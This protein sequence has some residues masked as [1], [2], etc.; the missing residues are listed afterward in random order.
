MDNDKLKEEIDFLNH[1]WDLEEK[2]KATMPRF[3]DKQLISMFAP[4]SKN[5]LTSAIKET[6]QEYSSLAKSIRKNFE[7]VNLCLADDFSKWFCKTQ[8]DIR[9]G[10]RF[11]ELKRRLI[12]LRYQQNLLKNV[13]P[14]GAVTPEQIQEA[15]AIPI[16]NVLPGPFKKAGKNL[17]CLC[18]FHKEKTPSFTIF[19]ETNTCWCFGCQ[20]GGNTIN[21][22]RQLE[23]L[24]FKEAVNNLIN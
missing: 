16:Q 4:E 10:P 19:I 9:D 3:S 1:A 24:S 18:P 15:L 23:G 17:I 2:C 21:L 5:I 6:E 20:Q 8:I 22:K 7:A 11:R 13:K 12:R 14:T